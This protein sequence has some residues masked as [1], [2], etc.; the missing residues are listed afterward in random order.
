LL[1]ECADVLAT[2]GIFNT[3]RPNSTPQIVVPVGTDTDNEEYT[4]EDGEETLS[5]DW[6]EEYPLERTCVLVESGQ[7]RICPEVLFEPV[8]RSFSGHI[9]EH[10][11]VSLL[12]ARIIPVAQEPEIVVVSESEP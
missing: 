4:L 11:A 5:E 3:Q 7:V 6:K 10:P 1:N 12:G 9:A 2:R 8:S